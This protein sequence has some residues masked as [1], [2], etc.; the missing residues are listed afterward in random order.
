M[1]LLLSEDMYSSDFSYVNI[2]LDKYDV[3]KLRQQRGTN[4]NSEAFYKNLFDFYMER[5]DNE[6]QLSFLQFCRKYQIS[7]N[8]NNVIERRQRTVVITFPNI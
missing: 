6:A 7:R 3:R 4:D 5:N 2:H 8:G 1:H